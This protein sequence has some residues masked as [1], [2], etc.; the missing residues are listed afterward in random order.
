MYP[1]TVPWHKRGVR[2]DVAIWEPLRPVL[3]L[4]LVCYRRMSGMGVGVVAWG[5][6]K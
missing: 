2:L 3:L 5:S 4:E 6:E 1:A